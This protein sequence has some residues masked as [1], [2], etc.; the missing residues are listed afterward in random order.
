[1]PNLLIRPLGDDGEPDLDFE[2]EPKGNAARKRSA[3]PIL[4]INATC[5]NTGHDFRFDARGAGEPEMETDVEKDIN[6]NVRL[7]R[8][9]Y[10]DMPGE[11]CPITVGTAVAASAAFPAGLAPIA[12]KGLFEVDGEPYTVRLTDGGVHDNQ[13]IDGLLDWDCTELLV[14]DGSGQMRDVAKPNG[15]IPAVLARSSSIATTASRE[16]RLLRAEANG[17]GTALMHLRSGLPVE[18]VTADV[19]ADPQAATTGGELETGIDAEAQSAIARIR[20]DLDAFSD[21]EE[22]A[23]MGVGYRVASAKLKKSDPDGPGSDVPRRPKAG[24]SGS[25]RPLD[26]PDAAFL[27]RMRVGSARFFKP[28]LLLAAGL[29]ATIKAVAGSTVLA[30]SKWVL[31]LAVIAALLVGLVVG[32]EA[33]NGHSVPA[34]LL[35]V[36]VLVLGGALVLYTRNK[37]TLSRLLCESVVPFLLAISGLLSLTSLTFMAEGALH[38]QWVRSDGRGLLRVVLSAIG[39]GLVALLLI[40]LAGGVTVALVAAGVLG[41]DA[42]IN[43]PTSLHELVAFGKAWTAIRWGAVS[44][45]APT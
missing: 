16:Q 9:R 39:W 45:L 4:L 40:A 5:L 23:I 13:G 33:L 2:P 38:R 41:L 22:A 31:A 18:V 44:L 15:I 8:T 32:F 6:P 27:R 12:I 7:A 20:T 36:A 43:K 25:R 29:G 10:E 30:V 14:S 35:A 26:D 21:I 28:L 42:V 17:K 11:L 24:G 19:N 34:P 37:N 3:V 1:M